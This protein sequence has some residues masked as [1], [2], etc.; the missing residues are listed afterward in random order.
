MSDLGSMTGET[1]K[2]SVLTRE[3]RDEKYQAAFTRAVRIADET[4]ERVGGSS[5]HWIRDCFQ[6]ALE[7]EGLITFFDGEI[8]AMR[9]DFKK[10]E[11]NA[12]A[13]HKTLL[14]A[15]EDSRTMRAE[16]ERLKSDAV[17]LERNAD[18]TLREA[19][20]DAE[21]RLAELAAAL[22]KKTEEAREVKEA[23]RLVLEKVIAAAPAERWLTDLYAILAEGEG[24]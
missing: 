9:E 8:A 22:R 24:R 3:E 11:D 6:P 7:D 15:E 17:I 5:R 4:F 23:L 12:T 1:G 19:C 13:W 10:A 18:P 16:V 2:G 14:L 20:N 21:A